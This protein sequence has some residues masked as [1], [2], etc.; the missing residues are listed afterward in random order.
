MRLGPALRARLLL[1]AAGCLLSSTAQA[2]GSSDTI[3]AEALFN[4]GIELMDQQRYADACPKFEDSQKL[5]PALNT[6]LNLANCYELNGQ[7]AHAWEA[8]KEAAAAAR[9][10]NKPQYQKTAEQHVAAL[11]PKLV[12]LQISVSSPPGGLV[13]KRDGSAVME[14][15]IGV[16]CPVGP[17]QH[18][19]EATA[20]DHKTWSQTLDV[21]GAGTTVAVAVP[22]LEAAPPPPAPPVPPSPTEAPPGAESPPAHASSWSTQK[23]LALVAAGVGVAGLAAGTVFVLVAKGKYDDSLADC[24]PNL[25]NLCTQQGVSLRDDARSAGNLAT[26]GFIVGAAGLVAGA[27]LWFTAPSA[28]RGGTSAGWLEVAPTPGGA[29]VR[30]AW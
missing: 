1:A 12:R 4:K 29:M 28:P 8:W 18:T 23:T 16:A 27:T 21:S 24:R 7:T 6:L 14:A 30:G 25:P 2:Q 10:A 22:T 3:R 5:A 17:G 11:E 20:P 13:I 9:D 19:V 15:E 26:A